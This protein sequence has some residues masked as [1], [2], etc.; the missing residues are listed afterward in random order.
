MK[1]R[2]NEVGSP[3]VIN[4]T[5]SDFNAHS[6]NW[7][8]VQDHRGVMYFGNQ[9]GVLEFDGTTWRL[10]QVP[11]LSPV[12]SLAVSDD[13]TVYVGASSE[14][15]Y[16]APDQRGRLQYFSL[17][18][19]VPLKERVFGHVLF[20][21]A[22]SSGIYFISLSKIF[23]WRG[24]KMKIVS[25]SADL[26]YCFYGHSHMYCVGKS[27]GRDSIYKLDENGPVEMSIDLGDNLIFALVPF[28]DQ[29]IIVV[30][31]T[32]KLIVCDIHEAENKIEEV[33]P[34]A[35][36]FK[37]TIE[38]A[39]YLQANLI[40]YSITFKQDLLLIPLRKGGVIV[41]DRYGSL[42]N[43]TNRNRGLLED[44]V[45]SVFIDRDKN[46][47]VCMNKG[48]S[49]VQISSPISMYK[50]QNGIDDVVLSFARFHDQLYL[51]GFNGIKALPKHAIKKTD[52][53]L[54]VIPIKGIE[55]DT[56]T[57]IERKN[58]LFVIPNAAGKESGVFQIKKFSAEK[59]LNTS[60]M[61]VLNACQSKKF[62][63][64]VFLNPQE[65]GLPV[66]EFEDSNTQS[67]PLK[68]E[69]SFLEKADEVYFETVNDTDGNLW[70]ITNNGITKI[71]FQSD[72]LSDYRMIRYSRM[73]FGFSLGGSI[74]EVY[75]DV[76]LSSDDGM[77]KINLKASSDPKSLFL[78]VGS[79]GPYRIEYS[80]KIDGI[81]GHGANKFVAVDHNTKNLLIFE[82]DNDNVFRARGSE[83][84]SIQG[85]YAGSY[86]DDDGVIWI[87]TS[88]GVFRHDP[89]IKKNYQCSYDTLIRKVST[90]DEQLLFLGT[91]Y[92]KISNSKFKVTLNQP[93][94]LVP[95]LP[96]AKNSL[97]FK[98]STAFFEHPKFNKYQTKLEGY[99]KQW[100]PWSSNTLKEYTNLSEGDYRFLVKAKNIYNHE[101]STTTYRFR[102]MPPWYR[103]KLAYFGYL[104]LFFGVFTAGIRIN[105]RRLIAVKNRLEKIVNIRTKELKEKKEQLEDSLS[106]LKKTQNQLLDASWKAGMADVASNV[107]HNV[108]NALT[109][110]KVTQ[111]LINDQINQSKI[112]NLGKTVEII[113]SPSDFSPLTERGRKATDYLVRLST[114]LDKEHSLILDEIKT[115]GEGL[116]RINSIVSAQQ[117]YTLRDGVT[118]ELGAIELI[119]IAFEMSQ[120]ASSKNIEIK[121][122]YEYHELIKVER[123]KV[124]QILVNLFNNAKKAVIK[125]DH[126]EKIVWIKTIKLDANY[127]RF[128]IQDNGV[129]FD[130]HVL[131]KLFIFDLN[132]Q[133]NAQDL[134]LHSSANTAKSIGGSLSVESEGLGKGA[135]FFLDLPIQ[136]KVSVQ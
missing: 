2:S 93:E 114:Q 68:F 19:E 7:V 128:S 3:F 103:T 66:L 29:K 71:E 110:V 89:S 83:L 1:I 23:H 56:F 60:N 41:L 96:F 45:N 98:Y 24:N 11:N 122:E 70:S 43:I 54:E 126:P 109:S 13:G 55:R 84:N 132:D 57:F 62:P 8:T 50:E 105:A 52:D 75:D 112:K 4:Y 46:L 87:S 104:L 129:G 31:N 119:D 127:L 108:G 17:I 113:K 121:R 69:N 39:G 20:T 76:V 125:A 134:D 115:L 97:T 135:S 30:T 37:P 51:A 133:Y 16:L 95:T 67:T 100:N 79:V 73:K 118:E 120:L 10:I 40:Q 58:G 27:M 102:I 25:R 78:P 63:D 65:G 80:G 42:K 123:H 82:K 99:E 34:A 12:R 130:A 33:A 32:G 92:E 94:S 136:P 9:T 44:N 21:Y 91:N 61:L 124:V 88:E 59:V 74:D 106:K 49:Y 90:T 48:I 14:F 107:I 72:K 22:T 53:K 18:S 81:N 28:S 116:N 64:I 15:G 35:N 6:Q 5:T 85:Q 101:S 36:Y 26:G 38:V 86:V 47:W 131:S 111:N 117:K 77:R